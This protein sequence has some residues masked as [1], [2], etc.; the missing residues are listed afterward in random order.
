MPGETSK[1]IIQAAVQYHPLYPPRLDPE[2]LPICINS[3]RL[4]ALMNYLKATD[5]SLA[6][7]LKR[8]M[9]SA[10]DRT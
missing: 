10:S 6:T 9:A 7:E 8:R 4:N 1:D 3:K 2:K 5:E